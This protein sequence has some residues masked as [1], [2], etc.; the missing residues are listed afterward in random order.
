M[1]SAKPQHGS[2][3]EAI[4]LSATSSGELESGTVIEGRVKFQKIHKA[5]CLSCTELCEE[6][7]GATAGC[8]QTKTES[9]KVR[10]ATVFLVQVGPIETE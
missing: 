3:G 8:A 4:I 6:H 7:L 10:Q 5:A 9:A 1:S 2:R